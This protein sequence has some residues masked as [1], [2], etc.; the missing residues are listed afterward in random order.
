MSKEIFYSF[1]E[2]QE[3]HTSLLEK[4]FLEYEEAEEIDFFNS[5]IKNYNIC[6]QIVN[7]PIDQAFNKWFRIE[8]GT[9]LKVFSIS[10]K[11]FNFIF[12]DEN[13]KYYYKIY[14]DFEKLPGE[15]EKKVKQS[16]L[17]FAK[18]ISFLETKKS[19]IERPVN[20]PENI[21]DLDL[22]ASNAVQK[23]LYL[24]ELGVI[25]F[26]RT[27]QPF[28]TSINSLANVLTAI[29]GEKQRTLQPYLNALLSNTGAEN[30]H[31]YHTESTVEKIKSQ[32]T[33]IGFK[34]D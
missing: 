9:D 10:E 23:I 11:T 4:Y 6:L 14:S 32:L 3:K 16:R 29:T 19:E 21:T 27:K 18:I 7:L 12:E 22:S 17:S 15:A 20:K 24:N 2:Y 34:G 25:D 1:K 5:E 31:P 28:N 8:T 26:L 13:E 30:K 33:N